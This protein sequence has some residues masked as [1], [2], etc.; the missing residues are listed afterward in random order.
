MSEPVYTFD[1]A[2]DTLLIIFMLGEKATKIE[3]TDH[4]IL[5]INKT[6]R[7]VA[8]ITLLDYSLLVQQTAYGSCTFPLTGLA[9]L[10]EDVRELVLDLLHESPCKEIIRIAA[11]TP[12]DRHIIPVVQVQPLVIESV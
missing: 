9:E 1:E 5:H 10:N 7:Y 3:L 8:R 6:A 2:S 11:Y 12:N 4:I